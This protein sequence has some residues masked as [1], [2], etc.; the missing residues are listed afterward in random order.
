MVFDGFGRQVRSEQRES[1][2]KCISTIQSYDGLGRVKAAPS[3]GLLPRAAGIKVVTKSIRYNR[4]YRGCGNRPYVNILYRYVF[5]EIFVSTLIGT[6][7]FTFVLFLQTIGSVME[8]LIGPNVSGRQTIYLFLLMVPRTLVFTIPMGVLVGVLVGLGRMATDGEI[9]AMRAAGIP[10][11]RL[12]LPIA[13]WAL[14]GASASSLTTHYL[15]PWAQRELQSMRESLKISQATA[16]I[17]P[18]IFVEN[19]PDF[20]LYVREVLPADT[21][22]LKHVFVADMR[23]P[24]LRGSFSGLNATVSGPRITLAEQAFAIPILE[25]N[26][27]QLNLP[28]ASR[29]E[30]SSDPDQYHFSEYED[31]DQV[32][33]FETT[34]PAAG[35][36]PFE[37]MS[38][39]ELAA[40][41]RESD[42]PILAG[43]ELHQRFAFPMTCLI[44]P[45]VGIPLAIS[46]QRSSRSVGVVL[47]IALVFIYWMIW[48]SGVAMANAEILPVGLALWMGNIIFGVAGLLMLA[49]L[50]SPKSR[51]FAA[52]VLR[53]FRRW[54]MWL[55]SRR[56]QPGEATGRNQGIEGKRRGGRELFAAVF[57]DHGSLP[58]FDVPVLLRRHGGQL[59]IDMVR[60]QF[61]RAVARHARTRQ[62]RSVHPVHL[63]PDAVPDLRNRAARCTGR[64]VDYILHPR[65]A[66]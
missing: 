65:E 9:T 7:L 66:S 35:S 55:Q 4:A 37:Q 47:G 36:S 15:N 28:S 31:I 8:L 52:A 32:L 30:Q 6:L 3:T 62:A 17:Q 51:D 18:R 59:C 24:E 44:F 38:T 16:Q 23:T 22:R 20:V 5:R 64:H 56:S 40:A 12:I 27:V 42:Q 49:R 48:L 41:A 34:T 10:G 19:F 26:R 46:S 61:L 63:L 21:A 2:A 53:P 11:R 57:P 43:V 58:A 60:L 45:M 39:P 1:G 50:D 29:Y 14:L 25:Q 54:A 33:E 13:V